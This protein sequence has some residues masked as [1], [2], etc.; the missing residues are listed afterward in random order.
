MALAA[1]APWYH[2]TGNRDDGF[3]S[4]S[5]ASLLHSIYG[6]QAS[7]LLFSS[8]SGYGSESNMPA[9]AAG[10]AVGSIE[11][12]RGSV[13]TGQASAAQEGHGRLQ[14]ARLQ[15]RVRPKSSPLSGSAS[16]AQRSQQPMSVKLSVRK[17]SIEQYKMPEE[18]QLEGA[19]GWSSEQPP[20]SPVVAEPRGAAMTAEG[21][22]GRQL[23]KRPASAAVTSLRRPPS[24]SQLGGGQNHRRP[25]FNRPKTALGIVSSRRLIWLHNMCFF[26]SSVSENHRLC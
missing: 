24:A 11:K 2:S 23:A 26:H 1:K 8:S 12:A 14:K 13:A 4:S 18:A 7:Q 16:R 3:E 10:T 20:P 9:A 21:G 19:V 5:S 15:H 17:T 22:R 25:A 6:S